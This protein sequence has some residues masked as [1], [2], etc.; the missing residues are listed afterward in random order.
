MNEEEEEEDD[1]EDPT[2]PYSFVTLNPMDK[3]LE[4]EDKV[5]T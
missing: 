3:P 5:P 1:D 2:L 4:E